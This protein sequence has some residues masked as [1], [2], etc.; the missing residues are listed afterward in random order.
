TA[1]GAALAL[2]A[3]SRADAGTAA[4]MN[5]AAP[6]CTALRPQVMF[7]RW[8]EDWSVLANPRVPAK[9]MDGLKYLPLGGDPESWL[10]LGANLRER[11]EFND[12]PIFGINPG[13]ADTYVIQRAEVSADAHVAQHW[14]FFVQLEDARAFGKDV[15]TPV[16]KNPLD[17]E[18]AFVAWVSPLAG[19]T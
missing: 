7:N 3:G 18:Q 15:V 2:S 19:G 6:A 17:L 8:Q 16:D 10:S 14:Q 1:A 4:S 9:P 12:A 5:T 13:R 11:M